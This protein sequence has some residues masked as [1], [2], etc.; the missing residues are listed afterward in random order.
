M[1]LF[2]FEYSFDRDDL[3]YIWQNIA[4][5]NYKKVTFQASSVAHELINRELLDESVLAENE[6]L[7][8]MV[9]KVKQRAEK[10]YWDLIPSQ[11][12]AETAAPRSP[13]MAFVPPESLVDKLGYNW[14]YDYLSFVELIKME[15]QILYQAPDPGKESPELTEE[16]A[17]GGGT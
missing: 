7:R 4:P 16:E 15:A 3:S 12:G 1:Y 9:F 17:A 6:N 10:Q 2:E 8:W 11:V 14:P 5:R 13:P